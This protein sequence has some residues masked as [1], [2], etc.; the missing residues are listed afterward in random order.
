MKPSQALIWRIALVM[1]AVAVMAFASM[2][3]LSGDAETKEA[4]FSGRRL[5]IDRDTLMVQG[6]VFASEAAE[7]PKPEEKIPEPS[8]EEKPEPTA[9]D[10]PTEVK[11]QEKKTQELKPEESAPKEKPADSFLDEKSPK[12][13]QQE[14]KEEEKP[15]EVKTIQTEEKIVGPTA[16]E[17]EEDNAKV[18]KAI[19]ALP[20]LSS[21]PNLTPSTNALPDINKALSE[22][23]DDGWLPIIGADGTKPWKFYA[24]PTNLKKGTTMIAVLVTGLGQN[25]IVTE[26]AIQLPEAI[27]LSFNPYARD[28]Q[29]WG[30]ASRVTGHETLIDLP[31]EPG[32]YPAV[33]PGPYGLLVEKG[34]QEN[35]RRLEWV[36]SRFGSYVGLVIPLNER[37]SGNA[38]AFKILLQSVANRG[39]I[40]VM[41]RE[42]HKSETKTLVESSAT[43]MV[44][45]DML[46]DEELSPSAI[47]TRLTALEQ[48][49]KKR[50]Y[51]VGVV[52]PFPLSIEQLKAWSETLKEKGIV[53]VP[54]SAVAKLRF[55]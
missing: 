40:M 14:S 10:G 16:K 47:Q 27:S 26:N 41:A 48:L 23:S 4:F 24:K 19:T 43:V 38:E 53:L 29:G 7:A 3:W 6:K 8:S 9:N 11:T 22:K 34:P 45:A 28:T 18:A 13:S 46:I 37:F 49:A 50:G 36:L 17:I 2:I 31:L 25:K 52:Q 5:V 20:L 30:R 39:L 51:A 54:I 55:S 44:V 33:D 12:E 1:S 32:N 15:A 21:A 35:E 42:P